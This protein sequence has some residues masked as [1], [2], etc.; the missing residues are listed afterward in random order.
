MLAAQNDQRMQSIKRRDFIKI[1]G[2]LTAGT[3]LAGCSGFRSGSDISD[4][5]KMPVTGKVIDAHLHVVAETV[6]RCIRVMDDNYIQYGINIGIGGDGFTEFIDA[7]KNSKDRLGA[8]YSFDWSL[9]QKDPSFAE[10]APDMLEMAV[11]AGALGVKIFKELGLKIRDHEGKLVKI[12]D[13]RLFPIWEKAGQ[14]NTIVA[15]HTVDPVAFFEPWNSENERWKELELHPE[16]SFS[17]RDKYPA[18]N[19][20]LVQRNNVIRTFKKVRFHCAHVG[21]CSE[22]LNIVDRWLD[23]MPNMF[24]DLAA[25]FGELGRHPAAEGEKF[26]TK[27]QDRLMFGTDR[28]FRTDGDVQGAGPKKIFT[29][30]ED[31]RFYESHWRYLQTLDKQFEHPTPIQ[32]DWKIDGIGLPET[33]LEK[34]YWN[35]AFKLYNIQQFI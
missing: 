16:W 9:W 7:I 6:E 24:L 1:T 3:A 29:S 28:M 22:N 2:T 19:E 20:V 33:I 25:R 34:I 31:N 14:L 27:H 15:I 12:D 10:K 32:G 4:L 30:E 35:N 26:F 5:T 17:D 23:E 21:N 18:R 8:L 13:P 11:E